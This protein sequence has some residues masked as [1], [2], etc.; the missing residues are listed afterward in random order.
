M[1]GATTESVARADHCGDVGAPST[2]SL[3]VL[4]QTRLI[5]PE[6]ARRSA[7][8]RQTRGN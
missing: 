8:L 2:P 7:L 1:S 5:S 3:L 4:V 6:I